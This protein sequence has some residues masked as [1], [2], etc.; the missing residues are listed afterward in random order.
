MHLLEAWTGLAPLELARL[1]GMPLAILLAALLPGR[2]VAAAAAIVVAVGVAALDELAAPPVVRAG[3]VAL[4]LLVAWQAG[5]R[6][7]D[8]G[9][10]RARRRGAFEA[11]LVALPLGVGLILLLLASL[12]RQALEGADARRASLGALVLGA[13]LLHLMLRRHARRALVAFA[14]LGLG[15]ELLAAAAR[16]ADVL[17]AG[18]RAGAALAAALVAVALAARVVGARERFAGSPMVTDAHELHD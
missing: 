15:L 4:W 14:A 6:G 7:R 11:G 5:A 17:H 13:G 12:S 1:L 3:W 10:P 2:R 16:S 8:D 9:A 18:P